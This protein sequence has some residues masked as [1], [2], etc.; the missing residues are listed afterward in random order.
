MP[1][2]MEFTPILTDRQ[3]RLE[4]I[5]KLDKLEALNPLAVIA[6]HKIPEND[7][8]PPNHRRDAAI[9]PGFHCPG[10]GDDD[11]APALRRDAR[12]LSRSC[13]SG[14]ALGCRKHR[15]E[16]D[17]SLTTRRT[18]RRT[19]TRL[20]GFATVIMNDAPDSQGHPNGRGY[21][22]HRSNP[23]RRSWRNPLRIPALR[24]GKRNAARLPSTLPRRP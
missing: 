7:D 3:S 24:L 4:W 5:S 17:L 8:D 13:Q 14:L 18:S 15:E 10:R 23:V 6:G 9:D 22:R 20:T 1:S 11:C 12:A 16:A 2:I 19:T 21:P